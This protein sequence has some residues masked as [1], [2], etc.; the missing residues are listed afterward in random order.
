MTDTHREKMF[1]T[2]LKKITRGKSFPRAKRKP[3]FFSRPALIPRAARTVLQLHAV[4]K[5]LQ[6]LRRQLD[7]CSRLAGALSSDGFAAFAWT[8]GDATRDLKAQNLN[9]DGTLGATPFFADSFETGTAG[10]WSGTVP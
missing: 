3:E 8:D 2:F 9:L 10:A 5:K 6:R 4:E 7:L 1:Q